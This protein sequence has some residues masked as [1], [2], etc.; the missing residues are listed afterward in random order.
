MLRLAERG[1]GTLGY[2]AREERASDPSYLKPSG[3]V[4]NTIGSD[5]VQRRITK[6]D[7]NRGGDAHHLVA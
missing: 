7:I 2:T 4:L 3:D 1:R 5:A 6:K